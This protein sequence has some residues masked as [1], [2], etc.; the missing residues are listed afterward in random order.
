MSTHVI[1]APTCTCQRILW[2]NKH[3]DSFK[4]NVAGQAQIAAQLGERYHYHHTAPVP[5]LAKLIADCFQYIW[6]HWEP[7]E[8]VKA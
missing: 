8:G 3:C 2:L 5:E 1:Q 7:A 4:L 6:E